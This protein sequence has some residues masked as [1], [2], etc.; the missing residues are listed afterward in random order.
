[1]NDC[2]TLTTTVSAGYVPQLRPTM[3][4][5]PVGSIFMLNVHNALDKV[6]ALATAATSVHPSMC[7]T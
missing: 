7:G 2:F 1:M 5:D 3:L 4:Q 6:R